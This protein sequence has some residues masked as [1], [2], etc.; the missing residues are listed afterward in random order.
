MIKPVKI[1]PQEI[2][3][4]DPDGNSLGFL[5]ELESTDLRCQ[6][7]E[8][9]VDGYYLEFNDKKRKIYSNG[10]IKDWTEGMYNTM[11]KLYDRLFVDMR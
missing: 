9:K 5:N 3:H 11:D 7:K 8:N 2:E 10:M 4:F 6:I 1:K